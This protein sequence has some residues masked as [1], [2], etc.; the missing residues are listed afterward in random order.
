M[1]IFLIMLICIMLA[2]NKQINVKIMGRKAGEVVG[3]GIPGPS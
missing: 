2:Y 3:G 1:L